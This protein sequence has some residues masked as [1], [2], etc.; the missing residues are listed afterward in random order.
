MKT[1]EMKNRIK[2]SVFLRPFGLKGDDH[3]FYG[4]EEFTTR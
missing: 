3:L 2:R 4:N 1:L